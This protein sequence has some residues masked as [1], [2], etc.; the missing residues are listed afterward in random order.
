MENVQM[1]DAFINFT[2]CSGTSFSPAQ[3]DEPLSDPLTSL[4]EET[5][6]SGLTQRMVNSMWAEEGNPPKLRGIRD[7][8]TNETLGWSGKSYPTSRWDR[9]PYD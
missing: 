3:D 9:W 8:E 5:A 1:S 7:A 2:N 6:T 4:I